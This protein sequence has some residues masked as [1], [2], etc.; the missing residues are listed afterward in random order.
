MKRSLTAAVVPLAMLAAAIHTAHCDETT[1][2]ID[3]P[4]R[5]NQE[6][7]SW[8]LSFAPI[9]DVLR[10]HCRSLRGGHGLLVDQVT[11]ASPAE[12]MGLK[13]DDVILRAD[14]QRLTCADELP[15]PTEVVELSLLREG[16]VRTPALIAP[17]HSGRVVNQ[18]FIP[19]QWPM[20]GMRFPKI[21]QRPGPMLRG[22]GSPSRF[23]TSASATSIA[24]ENQSV[25]VS[26]AGD[27]ITLEIIA[28]NLDDKPIR[29]RGTRQQIE[30]QLRTSDLTEAAKQQVIRALG[31][32]R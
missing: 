8:G 21:A 15:P 3:P 10:A 26:Q 27:Q 30:Q 31:P 9:P 20:S 5:V 32:A 13:P 19:P 12:Q 7:A 24:G 22:A 1:S 25:S 28:P 29:L 18:G 17:M 11:P 16:R 4:P 23:S 2:S 14:G 6:V